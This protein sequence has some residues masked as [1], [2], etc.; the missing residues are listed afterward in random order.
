MWLGIMA[1]IAGAAAVGSNLRH[2][3]YKKNIEDGLAKQEEIKP[4]EFANDNDRILYGTI[5]IHIT[6]AK[7]FMSSQVRIMDCIRMMEDPTPCKR[8]LAM[9]GLKWEDYISK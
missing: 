4:I 9:H 1:L 8:L 5:E 6:N 2:V 3:G 7:R